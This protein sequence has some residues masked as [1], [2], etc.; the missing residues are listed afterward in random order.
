M[1]PQGD[2]PGAFS[3]AAPC[4][5]LRVLFGDVQAEAHQLRLGQRVEDV[6]VAAA[7][8]LGEAAGG[9]VGEFVRGPRHL[10]QGPQQ[11]AQ[12]EQ[13]AAVVARGELLGGAPPAGS[14]A[15]GGGASC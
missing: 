14:S 8:A 3:G 1:G 5:A 10:V 6:G 7:P 11:G 4:P 15:D 9:G 13:L 12:G 2:G